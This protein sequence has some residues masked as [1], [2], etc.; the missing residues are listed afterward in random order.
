VPSLH[1]LAALGLLLILSQISASCA[2]SRL[3]PTLQPRTV[4]STITLPKERERLGPDHDVVLVGDNWDGTATVFDPHTF[5]RI[6]TIDVVPDLQ[7]RFDAI[8]KD[9]KRAR[10]VRLNRRFAG[11]N[12]DQLVDD[13][14]TSQDGRIL[15]ASRPSLGDVIAI[16]L[17]KRTRLWRRDVEG[18]RADHAALSPDGKTL[19]VSATRARKVHA[20]DTESGCIVGGFESGDQPHESHFSEDGERIYHASIG[21]V[22]LPFKARWI[23]WLKGERRFQVVNAAAIRPGVAAVSDK[24]TLDES[25]CAPPRELATVSNKGIR[26][27]VDIAG[28]L[29]KAGRSRAE[30]A[31]RPM[32]VT[33]D[34]RHAYLQVSFFHGFVELDL[35]NDRI[36]KVVELPIL[37]KA[38]GLPSSQYQL[39]SAHHGIA[40]DSTGTKLCVAGTMS[41]YAAIAR[42]DPNT[43]EFSKLTIFMV[44]DKPYWSTRS[45]NGNHCYVSVS[46]LD[47][48]TVLSF[49]T[50]EVLATIDVGDHPQRVRNGKM[51]LPPSAD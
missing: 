10:I 30:S 28:H 5:T 15:Y 44:G 3:V 26:K 25:G 18:F 7:E 19:L 37:G 23:P 20:I 13:L 11:E 45:A 31:V 35:E 42:K 50:D 14:F 27:T 41:G 21:R 29:A 17:E 46:E 4:D 36:T 39:N 12:H 48:V 22:F 49:E 16:D 6:A 1:A 40:L 38:I 8:N 47:R 34:E 24:A 43:S 9:R 2:S 33:A 51:R 32:A